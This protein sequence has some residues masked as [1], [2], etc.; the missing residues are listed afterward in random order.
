M[1]SILEALKK[2]EQKQDQETKE[3]LPFNWP[4]SLDTRRTIRRQFLG[5]SRA[6]LIGFG[7]V[8]VA[9]TAIVVFYITMRFTDKTAPPVETVVTKPPVIKKTV[10]EK[11]EPVKM[12]V[13][14]TDSG[15]KTYIATK[16]IENKPI[17]E[18]KEKESEASQAPPDTEPLV[19]EAEDLEF[20][21]S[22]WLKLQAISWNE[23][24]EKRMAVINSSIVREGKTIDGARVVRIENRRVIIEKEGEKMVLP[25]DQY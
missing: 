14:K 20:V 7:L 5:N 2:A 11:P 16:S 13:E 22:N 15:V 23:L 18:K 25:F 3:T 4:Q 6:G 17:P 10:G 21:D 8:L 24:P 12:V 19:T 9:A 1:S